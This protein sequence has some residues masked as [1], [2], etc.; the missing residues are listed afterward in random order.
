MSASAHPVPS[1]WQKAQYWTD[2]MLW[3]YRAVGIGAAL[4]GSARMA[5]LYARRPNHSELHLRSGQILEF[6]FPSQ[7]P[8]ALLMFGDFVDPEFAFLRRTVRPDWIVADVGAAIGQF[9]LFAAI[10]P[11]ASVC[12][13]EPSAAN[14]AALAANIKRN[15]VADR[16]TIHKTA[17]SNCETESRFDTTESTWVSGLS[18]TGSEIVAVR[19]LTDEFPRLGLDHVSVLKI[20]VAGFEPSVLE[21]AMGYLA[22]GGADILILLL[23]L[24]SLDWYAKV[25]KLGYRF[26]YYHPKEA[27]LYEVTAFDADSV[28]NHRP[29]PAR[30]IIALYPPAVEAA[31]AAGISVRRL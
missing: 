25:A 3:G 5:Y 16:V 14:V 1:L 11:V 31:R 21:G 17:L 15:G 20:N 28:L 10:L 2:K 27:A 8:R 24:G 9:T 26:F 19:T 29:W 7:L 23:G 6:K 13:F 30:N 22:G 4:K 12:A 18:E